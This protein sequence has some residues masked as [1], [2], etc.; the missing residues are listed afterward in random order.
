[1][2]CFGFD[3]A[4]HLQ[5]NWSYQIDK[6]QKEQYLLPKSDFVKRITLQKMEIIYL[7]TGTSNLYWSAVLQWMYLC[8][9]QSLAIRRLTLSVRGQAQSVKFFSK[10]ILVI[11]FRY[12][13]PKGRFLMIVMIARHQ[14]FVTGCTYKPLMKVERFLLCIFH[15]N[16]KSVACPITLHSE[17]GLT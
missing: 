16:H 15:P 12:L 8:C 10:Y 2:C 11:T 9:I 17:N 14:Q 6:K 4:C 5:R 1:M 3:A 7:N 13:G